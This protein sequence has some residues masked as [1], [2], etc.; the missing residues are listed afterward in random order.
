MHKKKIGGSHDIGT[1]ISAVFTT[2]NYQRKMV[3]K[4]G[5]AAGVARA[6]ADQYFISASPTATLSPSSAR[7]AVPWS[8][9]FL[10]LPSRP[11]VA[12][13]CSCHSS[14]RRVSPCSSPVLF[15]SH[16]HIF[17]FIST[18]PSLSFLISLFVSPRW[19]RFL[20]G[21]VF[22]E[23]FEVVSHPSHWSLIVLR[24]NISSDASITS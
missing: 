8:T 24:E 17:R 10:P 16:S 5:S 6:S 18:F 2:V 14:P 11:R 12:A 7:L 23:T 21:M 22:L 15:S 3:D 1:E 9:R 19:H 20:F 13:S 4:G